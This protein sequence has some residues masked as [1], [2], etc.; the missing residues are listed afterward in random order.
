MSYYVQHEANPPLP[1]HKLIHVEDM[2][3]WSGHKAIG[4]FWREE[5]ARKAA[6]ALNQVGAAIR[7]CPLFNN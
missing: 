2:G 1:E 6:A 3:E 4:Y 5:D 7:G